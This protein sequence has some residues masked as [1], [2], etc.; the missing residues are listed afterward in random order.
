MSQPA[1]SNG[2]IRFKLQ[3]KSQPPRPSF[4]KP[5]NPIF[6]G[7]TYNNQSQGTGQQS[8]QNAVNGAA[9]ANRT[10][11]SYASAAKQGVGANSNNWPP[12]LHE[13]VTRA[14]ALSSDELDKDRIEIML[15][16]KITK[17]LNDGTMHTK[18]WKS[19]PLPALTK[20]PGATSHD[21][22]PFTN[23]TVKSS[24]LQ[25]KSA[26]FRSHESSKSN[27]KSKSKRMSPERGSRSYSSG[28]SNLSDSDS[29][30]S[31]KKYGKRFYHEDDKSSKKRK[32]MNRYVLLHHHI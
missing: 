30:S 20:A 10:A 17:A 15:K 11:N 6:G 18:D 16:G 29:D 9:S 27:S 19:E 5:S 7:P 28:S 3:P 21:N 1:N 2:S 23:G 4:D 32:K 31:Y 22:K 24:P 14:F 12:E 26:S 8:S 25:S 13:Y